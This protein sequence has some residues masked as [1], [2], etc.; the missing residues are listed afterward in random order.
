MTGLDRRMVVLVCPVPELAV[1]V[2]SPSPERPVLLDRDGVA[3]A[4]RY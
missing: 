2:Q 3:V 1:L 4:C